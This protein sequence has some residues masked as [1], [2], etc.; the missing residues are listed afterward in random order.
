MAIFYII[1][2]LKV[3]GMELLTKFH[4]HSIQLSKN[5]SFNIRVVRTKKL[6]TVSDPWSK[7]QS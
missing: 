6:H 3:M 5:I 4:S 7:A 1:F 2:T